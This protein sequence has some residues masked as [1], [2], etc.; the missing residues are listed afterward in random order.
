MNSILLNIPTTLRKPFWS[1]RR[2]FT[3][4]FEMLLCYAF[5][6]LNVYFGAFLV[7]VCFNIHLIQLIMSIK[8]TIVSYEF[9]ASHVYKHM[10]NRSKKET[11]RFICFTDMIKTNL[12]VSHLVIDFPN[13]RE[14]FNLGQEAEKTYIQLQDWIQ[15][16]KEN[17]QSYL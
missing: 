5:I 2:F 7:I 13:Y 8:P 4:L 10:I 3:I 11:T 16:Y 9:T 1:S 12:V 17:P 14:T 15:N 6:K